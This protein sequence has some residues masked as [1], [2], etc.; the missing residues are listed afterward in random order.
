M[1][2]IN[3]NRN[4]LFSYHRLIKRNEFS[5][6]KV[7]CQSGMYTYLFSFYKN[8]KLIIIFLLIILI[9]HYNNILFNLKYISIIRKHRILEYER[10]V[11]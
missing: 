11:V 9:S 4:I 7:S 3:N 8:E 10:V 5:S 1:Y 6:A 2:E